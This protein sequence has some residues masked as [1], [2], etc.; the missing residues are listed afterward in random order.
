MI[1]KANE[2]FG[3]YILFDLRRF[4]INAWIG[5]GCLRDFFS[6]IE[7]SNINDIDMYTDSEKNMRRIVSFILKNGGIINMQNKVVVEFT[8]KYMIIELHKF[9]FTDPQICVDRADNTVSS[10]FI[11][12]VYTELDEGLMLYHH[13]DFFMDLAAK[14]IVFLY[15]WN[16]LFA[17]SRLQ[18]LA[19][20]GYSASFEQL[21][22]LVDLL[23]QLYK[24][25][26]EE[27]VPE[28]TED[29]L[30]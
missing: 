26:S 21:T 5:G 25:K 17:M 18:K 4:G 28:K 30:Q 7:P 12:N 16:P 14:R 24:K 22:I 13:K 19:Q 10:A 27:S 2:F 23:D 15:I 11:S 8:Y 3:N 1:E 20:R 29:L 9:Y 6:G